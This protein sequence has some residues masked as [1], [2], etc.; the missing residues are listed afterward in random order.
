MEN[1]GEKVNGYFLLHFRFFSLSP[2]FHAKE[3]QS[4]GFR[5]KRLFTPH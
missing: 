1:R 5:A 4:D 2:Y 3:F